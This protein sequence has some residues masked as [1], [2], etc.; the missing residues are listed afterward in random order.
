MAK[1]TVFALS[2]SVL[3]AVTIIITVP[4]QRVAVGCADAEF[5]TLSRQMGYFFKETPLAR[6]AV[7][8][9]VILY[10]HRF[11]AA[12]VVNSGHR[13]YLS[14]GDVNSVDTVRQRQ[15]EGRREVGYRGK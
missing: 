14:H 6:Q 10:D 15:I 2:K 7:T 13:A 3:I 8:T 9:I 5:C 4:S 12:E 11:E 1:M